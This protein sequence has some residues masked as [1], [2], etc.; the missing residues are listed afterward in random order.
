MKQ[1]FSLILTLSILLLSACTINTEM[2][3]DYQVN[4]INKYCRSDQRA[5]A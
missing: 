2:K 1:V 4:T 5:A 3:F